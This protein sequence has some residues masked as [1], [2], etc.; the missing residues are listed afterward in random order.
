MPWLKHDLLNRV[1]VRAAK[2]PSKRI[3]SK[4]ELASPPRGL[5]FKRIRVKA[6]VGRRKRY[7]R[8]IRVDRRRYL[9]VVES[10]GKVYF[11]IQ[12]QRRVTNPDLGRTGRAKAC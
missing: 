7:R 2:P 5:K 3:E 9:S 4:P 8:P 10:T 1:T 12:P 6:A 11:A